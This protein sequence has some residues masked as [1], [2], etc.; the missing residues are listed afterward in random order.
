ML[1]AVILFA[2]L[3]APL[4]AHDFWIEPSDYNA[5]PGK[6]IGFRIFVGHLPSPDEFA[7]KDSHIAKFSVWG[8]DGETPI[9]GRQGAVP[10]GLAR[11]TKPGIYV[12]GYLSTGTH[13]EMPAEKFNSYLKEEGLDAATRMRA[14]R[15]ENNQPGMEIYSR[16]A[17]SI[18]RVG[19]GGMT[20][21]DRELSLPLEII[22]DTNPYDLHTGDTL[23]FHVL[24]NG[25]PAA[26]ILVGCM[27]Q[28]G[29]EV[30][31]YART[32][33]GGRAAFTIPRGGRWVLHCVNMVPAEKGADADWRS[34]WAS[35]S[36]FIT[37]RN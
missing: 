34:Y 23:P 19:D 15:R 11:P 25:K 6:L 7:R 30:Q 31:M 2:L 22:P 21:W 3:A 28:E 18:F 14:S 10:A 4:L 13:I 5:K 12:A 8:P 17:K 26:N 9:P 36:F 35:L 16:C 27:D 20:G 1:V 24:F 29:D 37:T 32:D 33:A